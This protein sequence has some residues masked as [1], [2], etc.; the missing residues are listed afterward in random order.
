MTPTAATVSAMIEVDDLHEVGQRRECRLVARMI[1][2]GPAVEEKE[3][4]LGPHF[5]AIRDEAGALY[6]KEKSCAVDLDEH[7]LSLR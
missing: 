5:W 1:E 4:W 3:S 6:I 2:A 7:L